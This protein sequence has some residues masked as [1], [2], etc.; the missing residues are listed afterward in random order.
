MPTFVQAKSLLETHNATP[1]DI[2][3]ALDKGVAAY[4]DSTLKKVRSL[5]E[6]TTFP[7]IEIEILSWDDPKESP[8]GDPEE[9]AKHLTDLR[10]CFL[11]I[12]LEAFEETTGKKRIAS[13]KKEQNEGPS[14]ASCKTEQASK[15]RDE[16][17]AK[18]WEEYLKT[19]TWLALYISENPSKDPK[20]YNRRDLLNILISNDKKLNNQALDAFRKAM[21]DQ[22]VNKTGGAP[23]QE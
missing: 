19:A 23:R 5:E 17:T 10:L 7:K 12:D 4:E 21:P 14:K 16:S 18:R 1:V 20:G 9:Y 2:A 8:L 3:H 6:V 13:N 15:A 11:N 22:L